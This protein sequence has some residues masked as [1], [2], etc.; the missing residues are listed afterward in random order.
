MYYTTGVVS[1]ITKQATNKPPSVYVCITPL[2]WYPILRNKLQTNRP[3]FMCVLHHWSGIQYYE[4]SYKQTALCLCVYYTT[5][6]VS[7]ITKQATNKPPS[8]YVCITPLEWYPILRNKLQTN[9]HLFMCVLHHWSG[10]QYYETSY[11]QTAICLCVYYTTGVVSNITKQATNKPPSVYV[12]ITPLEWY[13]I[14]RNKLQTNRPLFMCVLHH[15]S[16][17]QYYETSYK[18]TAICL[19]VYYTTGV[20][21]NITKQATNKPPSVYVCI[22]PLEW[23]PILRNK[24]QTNRHL[25]MCVLHH[26]SGIQYYVTSYKQTALCLCVYYTTGVVSN[27]TK[28]ATNKPPSVEVCITPLEWYPILRNKLQ[29]NRPLF[30]CVLHHWSGIQYYE[31]SYK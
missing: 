29:I 28:Q 7:N 24:L 20:V 14:L 1:N 31:T 8:V 22:T 23:Y 15:W 12:C 19:C 11:K 25:F 9:R 16:G 2:E 26:W 13:P 6:V 5:G 10:I 17:I 3:L 18:Q 30:M 4:T 27:I 21:S